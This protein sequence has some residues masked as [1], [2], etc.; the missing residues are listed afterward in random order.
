MISKLEHNVYQL[1]YPSPVKVIPPVNGY[2]ILADKP[3]L[4][5]GG[6]SNDENFNAFLEDMKTLGLTVDDI[7]E[8]IVSHNHV[9][10]IGLPSRLALM[11]PERRV[12]LHEDEWYMVTASD[13]EREVFRE[14]LANTIAFWGVPKDI[15]TGMKNKILAALR[16]GGGIRREQVVPFPKSGTFDCGGLKFEAIHCPGHTD[17]LVC[18]W[19]PETRGI[20]S[21]DHVLENISPNPTI[22][23][24]P[25][26]GRRCGLA[27]YLHSL[28]F[29][30]HLPAQ[31][32]YPGHGNP[33]KGLQERITD[34]RVDSNKRRDEILTGLRNADTEEK[35]TIIE[36]TMRIWEGLG[37][38]EAYLGAR[39]VHGFMEMFLEQNMVDLEVRNDVGY[40]RLTPRFRQMETGSA[41]GSAIV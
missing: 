15:I 24:R 38:M 37:P 20:F 32:V 12:Y 2:L 25:R 22:Y 21:N 26:Q 19:W 3:I 27:D 14:T 9:D 33:F 8:V 28:S 23:M 11:N 6:T 16:Y 4:I 17:G 18:L 36:L 13:E 29:V 35:F 1:T 30:E 39:E 41:P 7:G 40:Y 10:H 31:M 34:I 5:D